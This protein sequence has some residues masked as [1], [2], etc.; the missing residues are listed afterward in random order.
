MRIQAI[1]YANPDGYPP[2]INSA[3]VLAG[4]GHQVDIICR[5]DVMPSNVAYP[6]SVT[7]RRLDVSARSTILAYLGFIGTTW[8]IADGAASV[9]VGHDMHGFLV[10]RLLAA[11][12]R[13][14]LVY[15]CHDFAEGGVGLALGG[16][17]VKAFE[18]C[19]ART[20]DIVIVPDAER[21]QLVTGA[22]RLSRPPLVVANAP[23]QSA[24]PST[25]V[26]QSL[27]ERGFSFA[28]IIFRQGRI[29]P[30]HATEA[31]VRSLPLWRDST[32]GFVVMGRGDD[33]YIAHL[34]DLARQH[35]VAERFAVLPP[36]SYD[37]VAQFTSGANIGHALY[38]PI[39][40]N[41][42]YITTASNK[43]MEYMAAGLPLLVSDR[44]GLRALVERHD[45]GLTADEG[46]PAS[47]AAAV[48]ALLGDPA[49]ARQ[50]GANAA[51]AFEEEY[52][53]DRQFAPVLAAL[54]ELAMRSRR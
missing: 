11:R 48:N 32:W 21:S 34:C 54:E 4:A 3:R 36:V 12:F 5:L 43:I 26:R 45:C 37:E 22:L 35:G 29:G 20:A 2:I 39:H 25:R 49:R 30:G 31:T 19:F 1:F 15:H 6:R 24:P 8:R 9:F 50:M 27:S 47:I 18:N 52:R 46:D 38:D 28:Q 17:L 53:Y 42:R 33:D 14:P 13:R 51:R 10:A 16:R 44:P 40:V 7:V 41:N 23:L